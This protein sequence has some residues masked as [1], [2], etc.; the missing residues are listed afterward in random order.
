MVRSTAAMPIKPGV[1][2]EALISLFGN[3]Q[4]KTVTKAF[5]PAVLYSTVAPEQNTRTITII[6]SD[7]PIELQKPPSYETEIPGLDGS[8]DIGDTVTIDA[9]PWY[10][11]EKE[12]IGDKTYVMLVC[13]IV[14]AYPVV[15]HEPRNSNYDGSKLQAKMAELYNKMVEMKKIAVIPS[16][17]NH[18][19]GYMTQPTTTMAG[20]KTNDIFFAPTYRDVLEMG[21]QAHRYGTTFWWTRSPVTR[22]TVFEVNPYGV[23]GPAVSTATGLGAVPCVWVKTKKKGLVCPSVR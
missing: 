15:F 8:T 22:E 20:T 5:N 14:M 1:E 16:L 9:Y 12:I 18:S 2:F 23:I 7:I 6:D 19:Q 21:D 17:G 4:Y 13:K 10:V 3:G 11:V